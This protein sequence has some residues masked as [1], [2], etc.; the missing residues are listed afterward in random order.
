MSTK[1]CVLG[2]GGRMGQSV[3]R[4]LTEQQTLQLAAAVDRPGGPVV[5]ADC[6]VLTG[7]PASG[8]TVADDL[9]AA[10]RAAPLVIDFSSPAGL[11]AALPELVAQRGALVTG[12]TGLSAEE[13]RRLEQASES[14]PILRSDNFSVGVAVMRALARRAAEVLGEQAD[15]EIIEAH[16]RRKVDAPSGTALA[17]GR[18][19]AEGLGVDL[20]QA[21]DWARH[22][23]VGARGDGRIGFS[24]IRGGDIVGEHTALFAMAGERL[25]ITH[26]ATDRMIFARGAVRA[27]GWLSGQS[28]GLYALEDLLG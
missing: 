11:M 23:Q 18:S 17:V 26:K 6:G 12:T 21:A 14:I 28:A 16:H 8:L 5:G 4:A 15:V 27:A 19:V 9:V 3:M 10:L 20:D 24:V 1:V 22:G 2:A 7:L 13:T 25:E